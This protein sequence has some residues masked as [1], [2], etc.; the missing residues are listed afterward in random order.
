MTA[1]TYPMPRPESG[2]DPRFTFGLTHDVA[3]ILVAAGY[4]RVDGVDFLD[5]QMALHRFLYCDA[6][7]APVAVRDDRADRDRRFAAR[8]AE[9]LFADMEAEEP[10]AR[11]THS[12]Q[13]LD[14]D[15]VVCAHCTEA[16]GVGILWPCLAFSA[17]EAAGDFA[18]APVPDEDQPSGARGHGQD[19]TAHHAHAEAGEGA[20]TPRCGQA[21]DTVLFAFNVT[22]P[23]CLRLLA[24]LWQDDAE[25]T[26]DENQ[27][28][29][30]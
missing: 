20:Y 12:A 16:E 22:C 28:Q 10:G 25:T 2:G 5:L 3:K 27:E 14:A 17:A 21:G 26:A 8:V 19:D 30:L 29:G 23:E 13:R 6:T 18:A 11:P 1:R 9:R 24:E 15:T 4:P 7:T